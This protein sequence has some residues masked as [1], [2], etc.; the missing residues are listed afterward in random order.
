MNTRA[1]VSGQPS[2]LHA[3]LQTHPNASDAGLA[4][5][6][7]SPSACDERRILATCVAPPSNTDGLFSRCAL[8]VKR[9]SRLARISQVPGS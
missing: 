1:S 5:R 8:P 2:P 6:G 4:A 3:E 7:K 9:F